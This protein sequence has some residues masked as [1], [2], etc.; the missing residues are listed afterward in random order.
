MKP[1]T[2]EFSDGLIEKRQRPGAGA[3]SQQEMREFAKAGP[4][5][6]ASDVG[7]GEAQE[8]VAFPICLLP[9]G[10]LLRARLHVQPG[11]DAYGTRTDDAAGRGGHADGRAVAG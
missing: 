10:V 2:S 6:R 5:E 9:P 8:T 4:R 7:R 3:L 1:T 11:F